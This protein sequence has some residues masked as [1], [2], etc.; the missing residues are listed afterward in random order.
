MGPGNCCGNSVVKILGDD[1]PL[2]C[3]SLRVEGGGEFFMT[4]CSKEARSILS[5]VSHAQLNW[6]RCL[7]KKVCSSASLRMQ[8]WT[9]CEL[10]SLKV[11]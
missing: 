2:S 7:R 3:I 11:N 10:I 4:F 6:K 1:F 9:S 8:T 5:H